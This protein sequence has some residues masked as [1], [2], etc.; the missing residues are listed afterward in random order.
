MPEHVKPVSMLFLGDSVDRSAVW[1]VN[2]SA[3]G[4]QNTGLQSLLN[5]HWRAAIKMPNLEMVGC[6]Y[7]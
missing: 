3:W 5:E 2:S 1:D 4:A 7:T 6:S